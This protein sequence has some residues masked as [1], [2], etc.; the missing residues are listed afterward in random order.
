MDATQEPDLPRVKA[1][2]DAGIKACF[3]FPVLVG[4]EV[5]AVLSS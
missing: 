1:A 3:G 4:R 2:A 5:V